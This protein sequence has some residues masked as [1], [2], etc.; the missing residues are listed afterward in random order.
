MAQR[1][2]GAG[3]FGVI[4]IAAA[5]HLVLVEPSRR[6]GQIGSVVLRR[7]VSGRMIGQCNLE[8]TIRSGDLCTPPA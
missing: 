8:A 6:S 2:A 1:V 4:Y 7:Y 3:E 5:G